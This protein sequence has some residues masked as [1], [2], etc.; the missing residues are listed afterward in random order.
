MKKLF[1]FIG[2]SLLAVSIPL[3][4]AAAPNQLFSD[5]PP[6]KP[7]ASAVN[8]LGA[9]NIIGGYPDGTFKP[10]SSITRG[11]AAA[12]IAKMIKLDT[13]DVKNPNFKDVSTSHGFYKSIAAMAEN[14][15][16][17]GY[18]DGTYKP[19]APISRKHMASIIVK[20]F[21]LPRDPAEVNPFKGEIGITDDI[22]TIYKL[23]ITSG[24]SPATFSP[25][26]SI[27]RGQASVMLVKTEN[28]KPDNVVTI[29]ADDLGWDVIHSAP[30][31]EINPGTFKSVYIAG[32][33]GY[34]KDKVQLIPEKE[35]RTGIVL[36][37]K[38]G[39]KQAVQKYYA[40]VKKVGG[41]LRLTLEKTNEVRAKHTTLNT[42]DAPVQQLA[43]TT[44]NDETTFGVIRSEACTSGVCID[45]REPGEYIANVLYADGREDRIGIRVTADE[46][47]FFYKVEQLVEHLTAEV[48]I[49][50]SYDLGKLTID[51]KNHENIAA[52]ERAPGTNTFRFTAKTAGYYYIKF[53]ASVYDEENYVPCIPGECAGTYWMEGISVSVKRIGP[54]L[55]VSA[56][57]EYMRDH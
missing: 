12:I 42:K 26:M 20:A 35:G 57:V 23:G 44:I 50:D 16:I 13:A 5:V 29:D 31:Q 10:G 52:M 21:D 8:D 6:T 47:S 28:V 39:G 34:T 54:I 55:S 11:Q 19:N 37:G 32:K 41:E 45:A 25:N 46:E 30:K 49:S 14:G 17:G 48:K 53:P 33:A 40:E 56:S 7:Y 2:A 24:T 51:E 38:E 22:L 3:S 15:I 4:A 1:T 36:T 27:T 18:P 43:F 9:R